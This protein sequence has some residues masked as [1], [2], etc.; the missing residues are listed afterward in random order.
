MLSQ[1]AGAALSGCVEPWAAVLLREAEMFRLGFKCKSKTLVNT[2]GRSDCARQRDE[3]LQ[4]VM[5][6]AEPWERTPRQSL[7]GTSPAVSA[8]HCS[9]QASLTPW[10]KGCEL[11]HSEVLPWGCVDSRCTNSSAAQ[12]LSWG[13]G[14]RKL[15]CAL[16]HHQPTPDPTPWKITA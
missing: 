3:G 8:L 11:N 7:K 12:I 13:Q 2:Q 9:C 14:G 16:L 6:C 15:L 4:G 5:R 10:H 1:A